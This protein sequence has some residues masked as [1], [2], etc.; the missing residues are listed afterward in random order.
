[1]RD[2]RATH[3]TRVMTVNLVLEVRNCGEFPGSQVN[4]REC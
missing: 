3:V 4:P 2:M 1:M